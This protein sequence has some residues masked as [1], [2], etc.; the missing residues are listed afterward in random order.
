MVCFYNEKFTRNLSLGVLEAIIA[1]GKVL[2]FTF[3]AGL[4]LGSV[5]SVECLDA[6][7]ILANSGRIKTL[8]AGD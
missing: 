4:T 7:V 1:W 2:N 8:T 6:P 3:G 5:S